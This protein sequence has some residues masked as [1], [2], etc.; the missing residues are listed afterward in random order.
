MVEQVKVDEGLD[1]EGSSAVTLATGH[2]PNIGVSMPCCGR[3]AT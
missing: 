2:D 3:V 1:I